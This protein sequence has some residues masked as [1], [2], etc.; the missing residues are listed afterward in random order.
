MLFRVLLLFIFILLNITSYAQKN[1]DS[2]QSNFK[3]IYKYTYQPDSTEAESR[4]HIFMELNCVD[5]K[6]QFQS[7]K[8]KQTDSLLMVKPSNMIVY[9]Y[10]VINSTNYLIEKDADHIKTAE[11]INGGSLSGNN[12]LFAYQQSREMFDWR[13]EEATDS[14]A[15][16]L[17]QKATVN[18]GGRTWEAWFTPDIPLSDGPYKF[19]GLPG[20]ILAIS[21]D[22]NF[23]QFDIVS[24]E[25]GNDPLV[26]LSKVRSDLQVNVGSIQA[27]FNERKKFRENMVDYAIL[28]GNTLTQKQKESIRAETKKDNNHIEKY[29]SI[30]N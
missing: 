6:S 21:D 9:A 27:F 30:I 15:G 14:I 13:L 2:N 4:K 7:L 11:P 28:Q 20:L 12:E 25:K 17:C 1:S 8:K 26:D 22:R 18:F 3:I 29:E 19:C 5:R 23:F 16:Y 24:I 10:G